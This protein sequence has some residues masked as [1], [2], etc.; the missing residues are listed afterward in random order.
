LRSLLIFWKSL[1]ARGV[2]AEQCRRAVEVIGASQFWQV[3]AKLA[4]S[5][6]ACPARDN[7]KIHHRLS[8]WQGAFQ[9]ASSAAVAV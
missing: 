7:E 5:G 6:R 1:P 2:L 4:V 8:E 9:V 3:L